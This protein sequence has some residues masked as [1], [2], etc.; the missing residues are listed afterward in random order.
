MAQENR[1][2][3]DLSDDEYGEYE[4]NPEKYADVT[5]NHNS[6]Y[7]DMMFPEGQDDD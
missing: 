4:N 2:L 3:D 6:A 1:T 7:R 5:E